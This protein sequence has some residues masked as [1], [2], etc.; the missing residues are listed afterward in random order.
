MFHRRSPRTLVLAPAVLALLLGGVACGD[1]TDDAP[2]G[3]DGEG[4]IAPEASAD[5]FP[6]TTFEELAEVYDPMFEE[7][8]LVLTRGETI[9]RT[10]GQYEP[11][12]TGTHL[13]LYVEPTGDQ[14]N[15]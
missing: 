7:H 11:S 10:D 9:D 2:G 8:D 4:A 6:P 1:D 14:T 13:A 3:G 12:P 15:E 5:D